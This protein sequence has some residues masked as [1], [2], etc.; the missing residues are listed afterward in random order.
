VLA[1]TGSPDSSSIGVPQA[2]EARVPA[3]DASCGCA[4]LI[5]E[6]SGLPASFSVLVVFVAEEYCLTSVATIDSVV[7]ETFG[8]G[9]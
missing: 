9:A 2:Q 6:L 7:N 8:S 1:E 5:G 4:A 3:S